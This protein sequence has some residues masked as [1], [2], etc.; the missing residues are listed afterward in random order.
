[1]EAHDILRVGHIS[2]AFGIKGW[3]KIHSDTSP[4]ENILGYRPW[5]L[6]RNG[7]WEPVDVEEGSAHGKGVVARLRGV[8]DRNAAEL[9]AGLEIGVP[10]SCLP[11]LGR[12]EF[13]W[14]DLIGLSVVN[15][16]G[17]LFGVV[18]HL[19]ETGAN[20]VMVVKPCPGSVDEARRL[21]PWVQ[22]PVVKRVERDAK[23]IIV[24]WAQD[25]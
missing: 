17:V 8:E 6:Q 5:F 19:V 21:V 14:R 12:N 11:K 1:M 20:D 3:V 7:C 25:W 18:D 13:Y 23:R 9:L 22:G 15:T 2:A 10:E 24:D 4:R 16:E